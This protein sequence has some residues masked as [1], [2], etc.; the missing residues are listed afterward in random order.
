MR[1]NPDSPFVAA[2]LDDP[3]AVDG[4]ELPAVGSMQGFY[5]R[6]SKVRFHPAVKPKIREM[7]LDPDV[8]MKVLEIIPRDQNQMA[9]AEAAVVKGHG[10]KK[11]TVEVSML[12]PAGAKNPEAGGLLRG[13]VTAGLAAVGVAGV[14]QGVRTK[15][16][17]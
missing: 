13:L 6:G 10:F 5:R 9:D 4:V 1:R 7:G 17:A 16:N 15:G 14:V 12:V 3:E 8:T 11:Q 2:I